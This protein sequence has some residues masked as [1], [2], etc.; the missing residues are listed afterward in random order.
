MNQNTLYIKNRL[1]LRKPQEEALNIL[2]DITA[3]LSLTKQNDV[4]KEIAAIREKHPTFKEF[5]RNFPNIC[6]ALAT[7]VGKTR[8]MG[9]FVT[10]LYKTYHITDFLF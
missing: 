10:Y 9:A 6:F 4:E 3:L 2:A 5:E 8:L 1:S 7:G